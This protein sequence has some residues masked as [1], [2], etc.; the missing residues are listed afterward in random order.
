MKRT[1]CLLALIVAAFVSIQSPAWAQN[2]SRPAEVEEARTQVDI[3]TADAE[4]LAMALDGIGLAK[5]RE[6]VAYREQ[7]GEFKTIEDLEEV[8]GIG[9]ATIARNRDRII[10]SARE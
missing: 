10:F 2:D 6:I 9:P 1:S 8:R 7:N 3:N 4:T 5:A